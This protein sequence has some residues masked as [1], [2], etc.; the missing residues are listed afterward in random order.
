MAKLET[1]A[2]GFFWGGGVEIAIK[3]LSKPSHLRGLI[4]L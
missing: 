4:R 3:K 2:L 1:N